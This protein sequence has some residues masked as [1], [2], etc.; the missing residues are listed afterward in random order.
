[1]KTVHLNLEETPNDPLDYKKLPIPRLRTLVTEKCLAS[2]TDVSK[3]KK[4][5]LI[6]LLED[7]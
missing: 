3:L 4:W 6:K 7:S 5:E 2:A 1:M